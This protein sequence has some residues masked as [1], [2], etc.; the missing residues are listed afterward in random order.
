MMSLKQ[1]QEVEKLQ[2]IDKIVNE[3]MIN[4]GWAR[5]TGRKHLY[6]FPQMWKYPTEVLARLQRMGLKVQNF[7]FI[8][9]VS[10]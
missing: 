2:I 8:S 5:N 3:L 9:K 10:W 4:I 6:T 1:H 7:Y